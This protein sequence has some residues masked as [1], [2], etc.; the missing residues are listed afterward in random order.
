MNYDYAIHSDYLIH[1]T[2]K[3]I[4]KDYDSSWYESDKSKTDGDVAERYLVRIRDILTH[5]LW[6]TEEPGWSPA[7]TV[8]IPPTPVCCF[9]ELKVSESRRHARQYGRLGIGVKRPFLIQR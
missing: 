2:G 5:G 3:D 6:M 9:S 7:P 8:T 4:D 1:W